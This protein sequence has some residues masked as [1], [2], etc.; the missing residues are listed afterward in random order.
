VVDGAVLCHLP[1]LAR[2]TPAALDAS[3]P[4][5]VLC[6]TGFR[7]SIAGGILQSLGFEPVVLWDAGATDVLRH[8]SERG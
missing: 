5:W 7:S 6:G 2:E 8:A 3:R 4:V 1:D